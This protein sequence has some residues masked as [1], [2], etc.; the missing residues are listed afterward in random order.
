MFKAYP[1]FSGSFPDRCQ[2]D[3]VPQLLLTL[4]TMIL[5]GL[6]IKDQSCQSSPPSLTIAQF[7]RY[8]SLKHARKDAAPDTHIRHSINQETPLPLYIGLMLHAHT[9]RRELVDTLSGLEIGI[10]YDR[11]LRISAE[12]GN[13]ICENFFTGECSVST[14][15]PR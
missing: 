15:A 14:K 13:D 8:N 10:S 12:M 11:V 6:S 4:V 5:E 3:S 2:E 7:L 9:R 1:S